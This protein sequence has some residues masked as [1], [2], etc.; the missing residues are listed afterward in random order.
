MKGNSA[1]T[2]RSVVA[3]GELAAKPAENEVCAVRAVR[4]LRHVSVNLRVV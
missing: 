1:E 2:K 4:I 3:E